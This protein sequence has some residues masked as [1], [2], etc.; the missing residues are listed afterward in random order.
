MRAHVHGLPGPAGRKNGRQP[1][2]R[3]R[4]STLSGTQHLLGRACWNP[5]ELRD[6]LR[7]YVAEKLGDPA[8]VLLT[9]DTGSIRKAVTPA[10][11]QR[12]HSGTAG[13]T[14]NCRTG[15][16][17]AYATPRGRVPAV[18]EPC[19]PRS[20]ASDRDRCR[21]AE[22]RAQGERHAGHRA[23][24]PVQSDG[25]SASETT[26]QTASGSSRTT[27]F[28]EEHCETCPVKR[29]CHVPEAA[30]S[31]FCTWRASAAARAER[32]DTKEYPL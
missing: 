10:G 23:G 15:A 32:I 22:G 29:L 5:D 16:F 6:D 20:W 9:D 13:R 4:H 2:G 7:E 1:A 21:A 24:H 17:A 11:V 31:S 12:Q 18:R 30:R 3:P 28:T 14:G 25:F 8:G 26:R 27:A 19:L